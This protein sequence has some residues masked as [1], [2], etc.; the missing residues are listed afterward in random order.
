[1]VNSVTGEPIPVLNDK[2]EIVCTVPFVDNLTL[3]HVPEYL[4][5]NGYLG[6]TRLETEELVLMYYDK[7]YPANSYAEIITEKE[8]Y[9]TCLNRGRLDVAK[10]L[11]LQIKKEVE[12]I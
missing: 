5:F 12:V 7:N 10:Q 4:N 11:G 1:M 6:I 9:K 3:V 8:A 2:L